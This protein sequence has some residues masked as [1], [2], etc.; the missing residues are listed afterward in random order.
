MSEETS[1]LLQAL[2]ARARAGEGGQILLFLK[3]PGFGFQQALLVNP[4][5]P[6]INW[7]CLEIH[8]VPAPKKALYPNQPAEFL[9]RPSEGGATP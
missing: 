6:N 7:H 9:P 8:G 5:P 2:T 4:P 3:L 1:L